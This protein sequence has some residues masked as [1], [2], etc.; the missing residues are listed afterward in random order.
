MILKIVFYLFVLLLAGAV[1]MLGA[2]VIGSPLSAIT[3]VVFRFSYQSYLASRLFSTPIFF[4]ALSGWSLFTSLPI[5][6]FTS[7]LGRL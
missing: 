4:I 6:C 3:D 7:R 2:R 5:L 1:T